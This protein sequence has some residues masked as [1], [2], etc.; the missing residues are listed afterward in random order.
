MDRPLFVYGTLRDPDLLAAVLGRPLQAGEVI[1]AAAPGFR[2]THYPNRVYP[3]L[4]RA[5]GGFAEGLVLL[6]SAGLT[7]IGN[8]LANTITG[9]S[10]ANLI[11]GSFGADAMRGLLGNDT[12]VVDN[13]GDFIDEFS[14][15]TD[16]DGYGFLIEGVRYTTVV[17]AGAIPWDGGEQH[18]ASLES[19]KNVATFVGIIRDHG[20]GD[21]TLDDHAMGQVSYTITDPVDVA[22]MRRAVEAQVR[23]HHAA[24]AT[25]IAVLANGSPVWHRGEDDLEDFLARVARIPLRAGGMRMFCAHQMGSCRM[26]ADPEQCVA[27]PHGELHDTPGV[28]IG[29][30][31]AFPTPSGTN[32]MMTIMALAHRTAERIAVAAGANALQEV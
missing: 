1:A 2:A 17:R 28:W 16:G 5:P 19:F 8:A 13:E 11:D 32:P 12:Y 30:A 26:G 21:I 10:G 3:A 25:K 14:P 31:S 4:I 24:G 22:S 15:G 29:D 9:N 6:G 23:L 7:G 18:K 27:N 20:E